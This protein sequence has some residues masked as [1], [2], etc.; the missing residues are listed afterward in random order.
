MVGD[1]GVG[2]RDVGVGWNDVGWLIWRYFIE[3]TL[4]LLSS[5]HP[6][7]FCDQ[8]HI[9]LSDFCANRLIRDS[10]GPF[11]CQVPQP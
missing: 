8:D 5:T 6:T 11:T 10:D 1:G 2:G 9:F 7:I 3:I 4:H